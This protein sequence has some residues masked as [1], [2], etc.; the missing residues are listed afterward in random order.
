MKTLTLSLL[1]VAGLGTVAWLALLVLPGGTGTK[2]VL[3]FGNPERE[4]HIRQRANHN[5][6]PYTTDAVYR[7]EGGKW[8]RAQLDFEDLR[9]LGS[10]ELIED[11]AS[12]SV[13]VMRSGSPYAKIT[14]N[15]LGAAVDPSYHT[16]F[17]GFEAMSAPP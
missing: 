14:F 11:K 15:P 3:K 2:A 1:C 8:W 13:R 5:A 9:W 6:E 4:L 10:C 16:G 17:T 12:D 7:D